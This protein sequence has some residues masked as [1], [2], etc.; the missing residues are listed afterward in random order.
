MPP[1][2]KAVFSD[3]AELLLTLVLLMLFIMG[4]CGF[5]IRKQRPVMANL[6]M[7]LAPVL[8]LIGLLSPTL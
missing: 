1:T 3:C 4:I 7:I 8:F 6:L 2:V 5:K